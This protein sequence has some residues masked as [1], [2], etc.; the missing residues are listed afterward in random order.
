M[1]AV[2]GTVALIAIPSLLFGFWPQIKKVFQ[3]PGSASHASGGRLWKREKTTYWDP[4]ARSAR[5]TLYLWVWLIGCFPVGLLLLAA[6]RPEGRQRSEWVN[7]CPECGVREGNGH[8]SGCPHYAPP[9][10]PAPAKPRR[11]RSCGA[12]EDEYHNPDRCT[13]QAALL[14]Q[15]ISLTQQ[16]IQMKD[17]EIF[18][19]TGQ[20]RD[21]F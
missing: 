21:D 9:A 10:E 20:G 17:D 5:Q 16:L 2:V 13:D 11:C 6:Q 1:G 3:E 15:A 19:R 18:V 14:Q 4:A 8:M 12:A 7:I